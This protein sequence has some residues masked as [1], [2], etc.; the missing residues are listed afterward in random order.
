MNW[1][2]R[3]VVIAATVGFA[4]LLVG[5]TSTKTAAS[6]STDVGVMCN[7]CQTTY[8][9]VPVTTGGNPHDQGVRVV[10]ERKVGSHEC[11]DCKRIA[12][13]YLQ[14]GKTLTPGKFVHDCKMCGGELKSCHV[15]S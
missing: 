14:S 6:T 10:G 8:A 11:P 7:K 3:P 4:S 12:T 13:E 15:E 2:I 1:S 5:C 9:S